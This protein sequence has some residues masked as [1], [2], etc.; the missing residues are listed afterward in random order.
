MRRKLYKRCRKVKPEEKL[1]RKYGKGLLKKYEQYKKS[2]TGWQSNSLKNFKH[3]P[4]RRKHLRK[5]NKL[6]KSLF[7][8]NNNTNTILALTA[9]E[10]SRLARKKQ[11]KRVFQIKKCYKKPK[12]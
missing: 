2:C 8:L 9:R 7:L 5:F 4:R 11:R 3:K 12:N 1:N 6:S 10:Y